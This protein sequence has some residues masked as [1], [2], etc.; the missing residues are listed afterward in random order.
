VRQ[1][2]RIVPK[3][4]LTRKDAKQIAHKV[5]NAVARRFASMKR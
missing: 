2:E 1:M 3:S 5:D 4:K